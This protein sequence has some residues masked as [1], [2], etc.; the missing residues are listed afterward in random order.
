MWKLTVV[1]DYYESMETYSRIGLLRSYGNLQSYWTTTN[2]G[3]LT[4]VLDYYEP[5]E[6]CSRI[7]LLGRLMFLNG[8]Y[9]NLQT[10]LSAEDSKILD[11]I[12]L[13]ELKGGKL[14][15][16]RVEKM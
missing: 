3:K 8:D 9:Q 4:V 10:Y 5:K 1:L 7:E 14:H 2:L 13:M 16:F 11:K 12:K 15:S 6:T